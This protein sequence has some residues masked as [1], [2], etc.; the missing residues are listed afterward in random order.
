M[1]LCGRTVNQ[2]CSNLD[3]GILR[4][5]ESVNNAE[6]III[7]EITIYEEKVLI[8]NISVYVKI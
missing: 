7:D 2:Y 5:K 6:I 3:Y 8:C 1:N 4:L